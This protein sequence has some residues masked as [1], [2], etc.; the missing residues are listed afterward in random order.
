MLFT[1]QIAV[2]LNQLYLDNK[3]MNNNIHFNAIILASQGWQ[4]LL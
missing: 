4:F 1:N 2:F 3:T